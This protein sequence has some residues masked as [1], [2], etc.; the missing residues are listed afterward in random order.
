MTEQEVYKLLPEVRPTILTLASF[1][2]SSFLST[3]YRDII[4]RDID[5]KLVCPKQGMVL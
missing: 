5:V 4:L 1:A 2:P 3:F